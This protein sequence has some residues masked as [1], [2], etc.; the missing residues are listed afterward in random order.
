MMVHLKLNM[1]CKGIK[2][3]NIKDIIKVSSVLVS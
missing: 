1:M 3:I 2:K